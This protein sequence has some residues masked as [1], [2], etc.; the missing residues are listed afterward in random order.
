M[1][2][3]C[4]CCSFRLFCYK[5]D[6]INLDINIMSKRNNVNNKYNP[7]NIKFLFFNHN[8]FTHF[9]MCLVAVFG[10]GHLAV[11]RTASAVISYRLC[12][13]FIATLRLV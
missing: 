4:L 6:G 11:D 7:D 1:E 2:L 5:V 9:A 12:M 3:K 10:Q 13:S 8:H